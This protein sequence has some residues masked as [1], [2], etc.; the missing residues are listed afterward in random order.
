MRQLRSKG[1]CIT[2]AMIIN[3][4]KNILQKIF[5]D[6]NCQF[7]NNWFRYVRNSYVLN[8][9]KMVGEAHS[10]DFPA[11]IEF[12]EYFKLIVIILIF[13]PFTMQMKLRFILSNKQINHML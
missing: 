1:V 8:K 4:G 6:N 10:N 2:R 9:R 12:T 13:M 11:V 5:S 3:I 7:S